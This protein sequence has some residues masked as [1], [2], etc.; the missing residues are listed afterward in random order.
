MHCFCSLYLFVITAAFGK[1]VDCLL[2]DPMVGEPEHICGQGAA[3]AVAAGLRRE[4]RHTFGIDCY[5]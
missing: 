1:I 4:Y 2:Q 3:C 5:S